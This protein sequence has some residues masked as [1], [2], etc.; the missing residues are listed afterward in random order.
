[1]EFDLVRC[2]VRDDGDATFAT[3]E[4]SVATTL[5][6]CG[7]ATCGAGVLLRTF[8]RGSIL[9]GTRLG[10]TLLGG[11]IAAGTLSG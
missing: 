6:T 2:L 11:V 8:P 5:A 9:G 1:M 7:G 10:R 3:V 4:G